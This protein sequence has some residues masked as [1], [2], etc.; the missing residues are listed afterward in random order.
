MWESQRLGSRWLHVVMALG[1][2]YQGI[3]ATASL[4]P[5]VQLD[6]GLMKSAHRKLV[7]YT[8]RGKLLHLQIWPEAVTQKE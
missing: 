5:I 1:I 6:T 8:P 3:P 2:F 7:Y 4:Y